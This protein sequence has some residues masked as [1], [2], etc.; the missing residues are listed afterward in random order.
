MA[1]NGSGGGRRCSLLIRI[2]NIRT[3]TDWYLK[4]YNSSQIWTTRI[5]IT[6]FDCLIQRLR[7]FFLIT[8]QTVL[9][10]PKDTSRLSPY[11]MRRGSRSPTGF[12]DSSWG[13]EGQG[14]SAGVV[15]T[16]I[17]CLRLTTYFISLSFY[18]C[19]THHRTIF[20]WSGYGVTFSL[21]IWFKLASLKW[22]IRYVVLFWLLKTTDWP[23]LSHSGSIA[24][25]IFFVGCGLHVYWL[26]FFIFCVN[27]I[28]RWTNYN[29]TL[30]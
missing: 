3:M 12:P 20:F 30:N 6:L 7:L 23:L 17:N 28:V 15:V 5:P 29:E 4:M 8:K 19:V 26:D 13:G 2:Y 14:S 10:A 22:L 1:N 24:T 9:R 21:S 25:L 18:Y 11:N 27:G 16:H